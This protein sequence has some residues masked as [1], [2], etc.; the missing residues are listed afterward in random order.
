M[1]LARRAGEQRTPSGAGIRI[2]ALKGKPIFGTKGSIGT[3]LYCRVSTSDQTCAR[4]E[5]DLRAFA[6]KA[7]YKVAGVW[8]P[9]SVARPCNEAVTNFRKRFAVLFRA[10]DRGAS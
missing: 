7:G 5:R 3:A 4:Q 8:I 10:A 6:N 1:S 2:S 9:L